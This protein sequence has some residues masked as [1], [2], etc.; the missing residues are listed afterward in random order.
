MK[1]GAKHSPLTRRAGG[2]FGRIWGEASDLQFFIA[3]LL[4]YS[5]MSLPLLAGQSTQ[6]ELISACHHMQ[7]LDSGS[8]LSP[9][10][11][12]LKFSWL[13]SGFSETSRSLEVKKLNEENAIRRR[14]N[15]TMRL[16]SSRWATV[17]RQRRVLRTPPRSDA[18]ERV[19][20]VRS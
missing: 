1:H 16:L 4:C 2:P 10:A 14:S 13:G 5:M 9:F 15:R 20:Q 17:C 19:L 3:I 7:V 6:F 8:F 18:E 12:R 11:T